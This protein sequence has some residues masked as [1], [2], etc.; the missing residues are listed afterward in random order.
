MAHGLASCRNDQGS[1]GTGSRH[2]RGGC[3]SHSSRRG[4]RGSCRLPGADQPPQPWHHVGGGRGGRGDAGHTYEPPPQHNRVQ[5]G[6]RTPAWR[7]SHDAR[8]AGTADPRLH[9]QRPCRWQCPALRPYLLAGGAGRSGL[10]LCITPRAPAC[11]DRGG[12]RLGLCV[13]LLSHPLGA[14]ACC[15]RYSR[16]AP[17]LAGACYKGWWAPLV[18]RRA[19][20]CRG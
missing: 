17:P 18:R 4:S 6:A 5:R 16:L 12:P 3:C 10:F 20:A 15:K 19:R 11:Y 9:R 13:T 2:R 1:A 7:A 8:P 14:P